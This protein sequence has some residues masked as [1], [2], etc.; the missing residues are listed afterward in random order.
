M[1]LSIVNKTPNNIVGDIHPPKGWE[2]VDDLDDAVVDEPHEVEMLKK[3]ISSH[4][5]YIAHNVE[6]FIDRA[7]KQYN[8]TIPEAFISIDI[9]ATFHI[10]LLINQED[11]HSPEFLASKIQ[12]KEMLTTIGDVSMRYTFSVAEEYLKSRYLQNTFRLKYS[13][14]PPH[15]SDDAKNMQAA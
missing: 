6:L 14:K 4:L 1:E 11:Y 9:D 13:Y 2:I 15:L 5:P 10:E 12:A 7:D 8:I 3:S